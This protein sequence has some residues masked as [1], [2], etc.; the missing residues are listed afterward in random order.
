ML[1]EAVK[2]GYQVM[3]EE[4]VKIGD[5]VMLLGVHYMLVGEGVA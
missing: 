4:A 1:E 5:Q 2:I 3:L